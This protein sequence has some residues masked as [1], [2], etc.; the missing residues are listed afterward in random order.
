MNTFRY[1]CI[2]FRS[3]WFFPVYIR[4]GLYRSDLPQLPRMNKIDSVPKMLLAPLPLANLNNAGITSNCIHHDIAFLHR[5]PDRLFNIY[6]FP[7]F[8][9]IDQLQTMPMVWRRND[10][11][12]HQVS[13]QHFSIRN[14]CLHLNSAVRQFSLTLPQHIFV[15]IT[16]RR[17][18]YI[19]NF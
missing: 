17:T 13:R 16:E 2:W 19:W 9:S 14:K 3:N 11:N 5:I 10:N 15:D 6:M 18:S 7:G 4:P 8:D 12:I 1:R